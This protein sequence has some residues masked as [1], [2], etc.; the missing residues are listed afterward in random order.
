MVPR[1]IVCQQDFPFSNV[2]TAK[3]T[4]NGCKMIQG[5]A[6]GDSEASKTV[7]QSVTQNPCKDVPIAA[8]NYKA[9]RALKAGDRVKRY[10]G[11]SVTTYT[12]TS[13][14]GTFFECGSYNPMYTKHCDIKYKNPGP[15]WCHEDETPIIPPR[16]GPIGP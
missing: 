13:V 12:V 7:T 6:A 10:S 4:C 1:C 11:Q 8:S 2:Q 16:I 9:G 3:F 14:H 15:Y 5:W